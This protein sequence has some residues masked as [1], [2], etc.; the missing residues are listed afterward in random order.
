MIRAGHIAASGMFVL[1]AGWL[2]SS[3]RLEDGRRQI[4]RLLFTGDLLNAGMLCLA[5]SPDAI[6]ALTDAKVGPVDSI[7]SKRILKG[8]PR[9]AALF[10]MS[11][12]VECAMLANRV[13][14]L[15]W[16]IG[17]S[18]PRSLPYRAPPLR[19]RSRSPALHPG[20]WPRK[21]S[22]TPPVLWR[23]MSIARCG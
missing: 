6:T 18:V 7:L 19:W 23:F 14:T 15:R 9:L 11:L 10:F 20:H 8:H 5:R 16:D 13:T 22:A 2:A 21:K 17:Q 3:M 4:I 12:Q 1:A